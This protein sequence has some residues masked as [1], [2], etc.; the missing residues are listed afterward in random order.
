MGW[1]GWILVTVLVLMPLALLVYSTVSTGIEIGRKGRPFLESFLD[2]I[3][4]ISGYARPHSSRIEKHSIS[5]HPDPVMKSRWLIVAVPCVALIGAGIVVRTVRNQ[6]Q[7]AKWAAVYRVRAEQGDAKSQFAL[8][9]MYYYGKGVSKNY[10][11]A[12]RWYRKSAEQ[13]NPTAEYGLCN[14]YYEGKVL[15]QDYAEAARWCREAAEQGDAMA[16]NGLG[17]MYSR[18]EGVEQDYSEAVRWYR[19]SAQQ[20]YARAQYSL[21]YM[22]YYGY[23]VPRDRVEANDLFQK[24]AA[25]GNEDGKRALECDRKGISID[26]GTGLRGLQ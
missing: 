15:P 12:I 14:V 21:G 23:G 19:Q 9:L 24:A 20:G 18:G 16:Q 1:I 3:G 10:A 2:L 4:L 22:Y 25:Q 7:L 17:F 5:P 13:G 26:P 6:R 8:G 11:E